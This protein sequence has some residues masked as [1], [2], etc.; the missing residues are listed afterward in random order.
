MTY[1]DAKTLSAGEAVRIKRTG[2]TIIIDGV[3]DIVALKTVFVH[4]DS[5]QVYEHKELA[6]IIE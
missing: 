6:D 1:K 2:E 4:T 3:E 5:G